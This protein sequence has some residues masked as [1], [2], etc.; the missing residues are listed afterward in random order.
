[1]A[2]RLGPSSVRV[3]ARRVTLTGLAGGE[4][5]PAFLYAVD[6]GVPAPVVLAEADDV[7]AFDPAEAFLELP[8][9]LRTWETVEQLLHSTR[10]VPG[11]QLPTWS[12][13]RAVE[14]ET[15]AEVNVIL[16]ARDDP[17]GAASWWVT[18]N[19][20]LTARPIDL[21]NT[22][23]APEIVLAANELTSDAW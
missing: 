18:V 23:R 2:D 8:P 1:V 11:F 3:A 19:A 13:E 15:A 4:T 21:L 16:G 7:L 5:E 9:A 12:G 17:W 6:E 10:L 20:W 22:S 14:R